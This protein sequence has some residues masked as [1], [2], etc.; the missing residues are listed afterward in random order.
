M[1]SNLYNCGESL[2]NCICV[3]SPADASWSNITADVSSAGK[4]RSKMDWGSGIT[5]GLGMVKETKSTDDEPLLA[6]VPWT[7]TLSKARPENLKGAEVARNV[8]YLF[9]SVASIS[10]VLS[11][12]SLVDGPDMFTKVST[13]KSP[14]KALRLVNRMLWYPGLEAESRKER[15]S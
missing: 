8:R 6:C 4:V 9:E 1:D 10:K 2:L 12:I 7:N 11:V 5:S 3:L 14:L 13:M 15:F